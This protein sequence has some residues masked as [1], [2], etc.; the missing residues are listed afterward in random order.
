VK[1]PRVF[2]QPWESRAFGTAVALR[3]SGVLDY[4]DFRAALIE[5]IQGG[6]AGSYYEH[7][8]AALE[9]VLTRDDVVSAAELEA[10]VERHESATRSNHTH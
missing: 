9:R 2:E 7:W 5:E 4:E 3:D 8:Q 10:R 6:G 1:P